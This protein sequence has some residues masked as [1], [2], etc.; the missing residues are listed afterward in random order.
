MKA[1]SVLSQNRFSMDALVVQ[2]Q[3]TSV[4][5]SSCLTDVVPI[6]SREF[7]QVLQELGRARHGSLGGYRPRDKSPLFDFS[8]WSVDTIEDF[9]HVSRLS[10][11]FRGCEMAPGL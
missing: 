9:L 8:T 3:A 2:V 10:I 7:L 11:K 4:S 5:T 1:V 6:L